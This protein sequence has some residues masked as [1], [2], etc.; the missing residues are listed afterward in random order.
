MGKFYS[1]KAGFIVAALYLLLIV[2]V[3]YNGKACLTHATISGDCPLLLQVMTF[4]LGF[5]LALAGPGASGF[6]E[7]RLDN[8]L[9][10]G[11]IYAVLMYGIPT[12]MRSFR[13]NR[14]DL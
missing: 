7:G 2:V 1:S 13:N 12:L 9:I 5:M 3:F 10:A 4:P 11:I 8:A 14:K 6:P